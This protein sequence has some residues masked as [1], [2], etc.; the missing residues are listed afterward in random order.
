MS[1]ASDLKVLYHLLLKPVRGDS[2]AQRMEN[3]YAGQAGAYDDFRK[4]LLQGRE[5]LYGKIAAGRSGTWVDL[6][7]G[8]GANLEFIGP[9]IAQFSKVYV[10]DL[11]S[12]LLGVAQK[13]ASERG[14]N[15]VEA[16]TADATTWQPP[17]GSADVVT[18]SY[19][20]TMI[21]GLVCRHRQ[22]PTHAQ[23]RRRDRSG[24][25]LCLTQT[26]RS[27]AEET[28]LVDAKLLARLVCG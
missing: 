24:G 21:P 19:S 12:S 1:F 9:A 15:Q 18:F 14:W 3:F 23:T 4:R 17:E 11:A 22:C 26:R 5:E 16:I 2:H 10:V 6:G 13:R 25:F 7:G 20:L 8:T 27:T 28:W